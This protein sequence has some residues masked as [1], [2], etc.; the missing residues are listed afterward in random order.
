MAPWALA[1]ARATGG[2]SPQRG[3]KPS[4]GL[5][6]A[7]IPYSLLLRAVKAVPSLAHAMLDIPASDADWVDVD[8]RRGES[9]RSVRGEMWWPQYNGNITSITLW[10]AL[11]SEG[12]ENVL[13][14]MLGLRDPTRPSFGDL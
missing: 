5:G 4:S 12:L 7:P 2:L 6:H 13:H 8:N 14:V 9:G 10:A 1:L 11:P 3:D